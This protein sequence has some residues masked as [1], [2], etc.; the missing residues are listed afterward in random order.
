MSTQIQSPVHLTELVPDLVSNE[1]TWKDLLEVLDSFHKEQITIPA[2]ELERIR[3]LRTRDSEILQRTVRML[4]FDLSSDILSLNSIGLQRLVH[5]LPLYHEQNGTEKFQ[6]FLSFLLGREITYNQLYTRDYRNFYYKPLSALIIDGGSWYKTTHIDVNV[7]VSGLSEQL[8]IRPDQNIRDRLTE[9]FYAFCPINLVIKH[10][11]FVIN[12]KGHFSF[13]G[14][15]Q[16]FPKDSTIIG[17]DDNEIVLL[18]IIGASEVEEYSTSQYLLEATTRKGNKFILDAFKWFCTTSDVVTFIKNDGLASFDMVAIDRPVVIQALYG[19]I[20]YQKDVLIKNSN[21]SL[22][23]KSMRIVG[24]SVLIENTLNNKYYCEVTW[25]NDAVE[26]IK[27]KRLDWSASDVFAIPYIKNDEMYLR[28]LSVKHNEGIVLSVTFNHPN[29]LIYVATKNIEIKVFQD[30]YFI[31]SIDGPH[32]VYAN[33]NYQYR[34]LVSTILNSGVTLPVYEVI[35][36]WQLQSQILSIDNSGYM[37]VGNVFSPFT[38]KLEA[39]HEEN[40]IK[41]KAVIDIEVEETVPEIVSLYIIGP[42]TINE[43]STAS[44]LAV[45]RW[46]NGSTNNTLVDWSASKFQIDSETGVY[47]SGIVREN[48]PVTIYATLYLEEGVKYEAEK[49]VT[50]VKEQ[51]KIVALLI[52][53]SYILKVGETV[54]LKACLFWSDGKQEIIEAA[55]DVFRHDTQTPLQN[56][57]T[58]TSVFVEGM[59]AISVEIVDEKIIESILDI[60]AT[61]TVSGITYHAVHSLAIIP[62]RIT[63]DVERFVI[64]GDN[65]ID[66]NQRKT[67]TAELVFK[68][69]S[70]RQV[71]PIWTVTALKEYPTTGCEVPGV[72]DYVLATVD[73]DGRLTARAVHKDEPIILKA[74]YYNNYSEKNI[75]IID[76]PLYPVDTIDL[77]C[78][79]GPGEI[80]FGEVYS[81][82]LIIHWNGDKNPTEESSDWYIDDEWS[83]RFIAVDP[84]GYVSTIQQGVPVGEEKVLTDGSGIQYVEAVLT[85]SLNC[86]GFNVVKSKTIKVKWCPWIIIVPEEPSPCDENYVPPPTLPPNTYTSTT[87]TTRPPTTS[88]TATTTTTPPPTTSTT[89]STQGTTQGTTQSTTTTTLPTTTTTRPTT[90]TTLTTTTT[91]T[92]LPKAKITSITI[93]GPVT[94]TEKT[95]QQYL[96]LAYYSNSTTAIITAD[97]WSLTQPTYASISTSGLLTAADVAADSKLIIKASYFDGANSATFNAS[98]EITIKNVIVKTPNNIIIRGAITIDSNTSSTYT[99][100]LKYSDGTAEFITPTEWWLVNPAAGVT[101]VTL[102]VEGSRYRISVGAIASNVTITIGS[103]YVVPVTGVI[104]TTTFIISLVKAGLVLRP[105]WGYGP[106]GLKTDTDITTKLTTIVSNA[107]GTKF[108]YVCPDG[109]FVYFAHPKNLG[110]AQFVAD[111]ML[112]MPGG[113]DGAS[114]PDGDF[115][116]S[117]PISVVRNNGVSNEDWYLYRTDFPGPGTFTFTVTY[118]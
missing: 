57:V 81:Y 41:Q 66:E 17:P 101:G 117:G 82:V 33:S 114:W 63:L 93:Q 16:R 31:L 38:V 13:V 34:A 25:A 68:D 44:Y 8:I 12:L 78:I 92:T 6:K 5:L 36:S 43:K 103:K 29:G 99:T 32:R 91:T 89:T 1:T 75:I 62:L 65:D 50:I 56:I 110:T 4:G 19:G 14:A 52:I 59:P 102:A 42:S 83:S 118:L 69:G 109:Q 3:F 94:V 80:C 24:D 40:G 2:L 116:D 45:I 95:T 79:E 84:D 22:L 106:F 105:C 85:T 88:T 23:V 51:R 30:S 70:S 87:T 53:G 97:S 11:Y 37:R 21:S 26:I 98:L 39:T 49:V 7:D 64:I 72:E 9:I 77:Y 61:Y 111:G 90:T 67:Y 86:R 55:W 107:S 27:E 54:T 28:T 46:S 48:T 115:G 47:R 100:E 35:P 58:I 18:E 96:V 15:V 74:R 20:N 113:F 10:L 76:H 71:T 60:K 112:G 108:S 73:G 104:L